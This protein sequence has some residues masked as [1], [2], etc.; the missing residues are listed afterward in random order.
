MV[1]RFTGASLGFLAFSI[2]TI[3]GLVARNPVQVILSRSILALFV[4][5]FIGIALGKV[6][7]S[8]VAE[9]Q[10]ARTSEIK[11][12]YRQDMTPEATEGQQ[13][14]E[15]PVGETVA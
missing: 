6:A 13:T 10:R 3:A 7:Q 14:P 15:T 8:I 9:H 5:C 11:E 1:A 2:A 12:K 4:F